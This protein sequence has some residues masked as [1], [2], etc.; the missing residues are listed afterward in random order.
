MTQPKAA[1]DM[2]HSVYAV[3]SGQRIG[4]SLRVPSSKSV[5]QRYLNL[6]LLGRSPLTMQRLVLSEDTRL[7]LSALKAC[8]FGIEVQGT[9]LHLAPRS[10]VSEAEIYCGN[11]GTMFRF[12]TGALT[13]LPGVWRLDGVAR[14]RERPV[15]QLID[16]LRELGAVIE[17]EE[18]DGFAPLRIHGG[19]LKGGRCLLD[20]SSSSQFLSSVLMAAQVAPQATEVVVGALTS[21]P[22]VDLTLDAIVEFGGTV[23][24]EGQIFTVEPSRLRSSVV[25]IEADYSAV[26][27]PAA[28]AMLSG[29]TV[30][31][32]GLKADSRQGD[33]QFIELLEQMGAA[34]RW[35][36][37][38]LEVAPGRLQ[39]VEADMAKTPDQ[40]P[41]LAALAPFAAG[42]TRITGV[43]H[44][45]IKECDR[46]SAM[47]CEL[48]RVGAEVEELDD[49]LVIPGVWH[50]V[51]PPLTPV[52]V[53]TY[54]DHRIAMSMALVGLRRP[55]ISIRNPEVVDKSY[56]GFWDDL[57][58][59]LGAG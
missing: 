43:P 41:T 23:L 12:L 36:G 18:Q 10:E 3:P 53:E 20:A 52:T 38:A 56:P 40:V 11:G 39:A 46:L 15:T 1:F 50:E 5:A 27:Y 4:G 32:E 35:Q 2:A 55:G 42:T 14:L 13:A 17:C 51:D 25:A 9:D 19:T 34:I 7:F 8:G 37:D 30:R 24:R 31:I 44:L 47:A 59:L 33:R 54:G 57:E 49:G 6:A 58:L 21:A 16:A 29:G 48:A 26:A 22:Y 45:R 28:A